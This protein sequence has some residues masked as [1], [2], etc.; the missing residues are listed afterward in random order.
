M[1]RANAA[2]AHALGAI[3]DTTDSV[4]C[5]VGDAHT[6]LVGLLVALWGGTDTLSPV[7]GTLLAA[8]YGRLGAPVEVAFG[9][10]RDSRASKLHVHVGGLSRHASA[11][12]SRHNVL[13]VL[14]LN[15]IGQ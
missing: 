4:A 7:V 1:E 5:P 10:S 12:K 11:S 14:V 13:D 2:H 8:L 15:K 9:L 6:F 3:V